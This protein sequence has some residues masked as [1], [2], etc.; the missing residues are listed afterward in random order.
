[1]DLISQMAA[2]AVGLWWFYKFF[3]WVLPMRMD[4]ELD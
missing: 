4:Q 3:H 2:A 1:M